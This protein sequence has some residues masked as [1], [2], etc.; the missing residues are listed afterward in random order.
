MAG[1]NVLSGSWTTIHVAINQKCKLSLD[2]AFFFFFF[3]TIGEKT[4]FEYLRQMM[5]F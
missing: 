3:E 5:Y 2:V 4:S 1:N